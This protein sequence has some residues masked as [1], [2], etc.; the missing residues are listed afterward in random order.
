MADL[1]TR[2]EEARREGYSDDEIASFLS[3]NNPR[4]Q[5]AIREGYSAS[6]V[7]QFLT[8]QPAAQAAPQAEPMA[9]AQAQPAAPEAFPPQGEMGGALRGIRADMAPA[10]VVQA[11]PT[12]QQQPTER[13][14]WT[15][16]L[17]DLLQAPE[18]QSLSQAARN[19]LLGLIRGAADI[20]TTIVE[21][22]RT[23]P[24]G[25]PAPI[26]TLPERFKERQ[27]QITAGMADKGAQVN[28]PG[29]TSG[30]LAGQIAGTAG[31]GPAVGA[32]LRAAGATRLGEAVAAGGFG[33]GGA[34]GSPPVA[35]GIAGRREPRGCGDGP[36][37]AGETALPLMAR[38]PRPHAY[39]GAVGP[40]PFPFPF[41]LP[42]DRRHWVR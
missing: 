21:V 33:P 26:T 18:G 7:L 31:V 14:W 6:E 38:P 9:P 32:G 23:T 27:Q 20:G 40:L 39:A 29:F 25:G 16:G 12:A 4:V 11:Q 13:P 37:R 3:G 1:R 28:A 36:A 5:E 8:S 41:P 15:R 2:I 35:G 17:I 34:G 42:M 19:E 10:P 24:A 22:G 30:R